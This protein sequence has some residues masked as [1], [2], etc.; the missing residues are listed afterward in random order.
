MSRSNLDGVP[1]RF[2]NASREV[3]LGALKTPI[4]RRVAPIQAVTLRRD[5]EP[6]ARSGGVDRN[7][8]NSE[9][10]RHLTR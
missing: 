3:M 9:F 10:N 6:L 1:S 7:G 2:R 8:T 5:R 4:E